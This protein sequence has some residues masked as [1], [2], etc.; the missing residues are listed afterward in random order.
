MRGDLAIALLDVD[1][2]VL[3]LA[4]QLGDGAGELVGRL[5][6]FHRGAV[7]G[8][9]ARPIELEAVAVGVV[10]VDCFAELFDGGVGVLR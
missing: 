5:G 4:E 3:G 6:G 2:G 1:V 10:V 8:E 9:E 7:L